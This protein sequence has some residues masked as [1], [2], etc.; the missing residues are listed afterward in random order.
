MMRYPMLILF[1]VMLAGCETPAERVARAQAEV[2]EMIRVYG[3][4]CDKLG[5]ARDSDAWRDCILRLASY[6]RYR[7]RPSTLT[8]T[9]FQGFYN[10]VGY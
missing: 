3:P 1:A 9:G 5:Y 2:G 6:E 10:C 4:A 8:C 7:P